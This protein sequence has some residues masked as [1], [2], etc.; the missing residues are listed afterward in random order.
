MF[1]LLYAM[2][3]DGILWFKGIPLN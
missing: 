3:T 1:Y 2:H